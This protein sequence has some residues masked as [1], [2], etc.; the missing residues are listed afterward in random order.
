[1]SGVGAGRGRHCLSSLASFG[2][3]HARP[4]GAVSLQFARVGDGRLHQSGPHLCAQLLVL[5]ARHQANWHGWDLILEVLR[6]WS[7]SHSH[8]LILKQSFR[9]PNSN[10]RVI[11]KQSLLSQKIRLVL[12]TPTKHPN[13]YLKIS[14]TIGQVML[15]WLFGHT[16]HKYP[17]NPKITAFANIVRRTYYFK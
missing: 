4:T 7:Y 15:F 17:E 5:L 8:V 16:C 9:G 10:I 14:S 2:L 6:P 11:F 3:S 1:M 13:L 12:W